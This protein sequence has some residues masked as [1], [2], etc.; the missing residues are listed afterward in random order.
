[1]TDLTDFK[2]QFKGDVVTPR[3]PDYEKAIDRWAANAKRRAAVV[4]FVKSSEDV[5]AAIKYARSAG[6]RIA[7]RGGGHSAADTSSSEGGLVIDLSKYLKNVKVDPDKKLIYV[8]GGADWKAVDE[9]SI[10]HGL[11]GVAGTV[12]HV[13]TI[14]PFLGQSLICFAF[15]L[16]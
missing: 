6:L 16:V 5:A 11:A 12:N 14:R 10:K 9:A 3:D 2:A 4:A 8:Q 15:R 7:I 1:M 13:C